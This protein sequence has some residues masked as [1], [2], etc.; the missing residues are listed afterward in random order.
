M[1]AP[2]GV[3]GGCGASAGRSGAVEAIERRSAGGEVC[4]A[5][6]RKFGGPQRDS[7]VV[8]QLADW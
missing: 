4:L 6:I 2:S 3:G 8:S 7:P 1:L 5:S